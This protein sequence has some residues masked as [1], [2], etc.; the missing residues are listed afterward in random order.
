MPFDRAPTPVVGKVLVDGNA[1]L[2]CNMGE[3][4]FGDVMLAVGKSSFE[5]EVLEQEG[6]AQRGCPVLLAN[7]SVQRGAMSNAR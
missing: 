7:G 4:S 2:A 5:L 1:N 3:R 6:K